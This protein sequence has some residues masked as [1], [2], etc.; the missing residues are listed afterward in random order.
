MAKKRRLDQLLIERGLAAD[1]GAAERLVLAGA[2]LVNGAVLDKRAELLPEDV[3]IELKEVNRFVSR[4]GLKLNFALEHFG[5]SVAGKV[6]ADA[7]ASTGGFTDVLLQRDATKVYAIDSAYGELSWKL[8]QDPRVVVM[9]RTTIASITSLPD[10]IDFACVDISLLSL[11][12]ILPSVLS[13]LAPRGEVVALIKPQYE[14]QQGDVPEGGVIE[15]DAKRKAAVDG[16][17]SWCDIN[18]LLVRGVIESPI[19]GGAGNVEYLIHL[20]PK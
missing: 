3:A 15:D 2:V 6:C 13:W 9:E 12:Q 20:L 18:N 19:R 14:L 1:L 8:R 11:K 4:G 5:I 16:V 7:G 17:V 10:V